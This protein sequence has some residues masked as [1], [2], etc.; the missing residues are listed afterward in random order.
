MVLAAVGACA[1]PRA[2]RPSA[3]DRTARGSETWT[4]WVG[5]VL[6]A[7]GPV[8]VTTGPART[9][10]RTG[11]GPPAL[12]AGAPRERRPSAGARRRRP[13]P[14]WG[15]PVPARPCGPVAALAA[16][17][18]AA[19][20]T[21]RRPGGVRQLARWS[22]LAAALVRLVDRRLRVGGVVRHRRHG[23]RD[24]GPVGRRARRRLG[25]GS[26]T[27]LVVRAAPPRARSGGGVRRRPARG[28]RP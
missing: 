15:W 10:G 6:F 26:P 13:R 4:P 5:A 16:G 2:A 3:S 21:S 19:V 17:V 20:A 9:G 11:G 25:L 12:G 23:P 7:C 8:L 1:W 24:H 22:V 28:S 27:T 14:G 18:V